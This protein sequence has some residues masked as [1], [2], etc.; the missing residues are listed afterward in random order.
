[1]FYCVDSA[2]PSRHFIVDPQANASCLLDLRA[3]QLSLKHGTTDQAY[4]E[5]AALTA[6]KT[7]LPQKLLG[8]GQLSRR[9][10]GLPSEE[11]VEKRKQ[12][13]RS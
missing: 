5:F 13:L 1:M 2:R 12:R 4:A 6:Y 9:D 3:L 10:A 7:C 11:G 8:W